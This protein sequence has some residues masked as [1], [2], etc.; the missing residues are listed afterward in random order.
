MQSTDANARSCDGLTFERMGG[1]KSFKNK[2][3]VV[4]VLD[5]GEASRVMIRG[6]RPLRFASAVKERITEG[7][8]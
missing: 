8:R 4:L 1:F 3:F 2:S 5:P 6:S 7:G